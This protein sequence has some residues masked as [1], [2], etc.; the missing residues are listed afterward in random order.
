MIVIRRMTKNEERWK[1]TNEY[2]VKMM[3]CL[4][5]FLYEVW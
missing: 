4:C 3:C 1:M 5:V 2:N